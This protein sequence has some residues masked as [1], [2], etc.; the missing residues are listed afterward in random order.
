MILL[1][2]DALIKNLPRFDWLQIAIKEFQEIFLA[3][4]AYFSFDNTMAS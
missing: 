2:K 4:I 1:F 3:G